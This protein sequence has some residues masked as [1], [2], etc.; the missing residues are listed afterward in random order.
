MIRVSKTEYKINNL[1]E[2]DKSVPAKVTFETLDLSGF[3]DLL[4]F[5]KLL[6]AGKNVNVC[7]ENGKRYIS[8]VGADF[9][10]YIKI[11]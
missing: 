4:N 11:I 1:G 10:K 6:N 5:V 8:V 2:I 7:Y 3:A 9:R